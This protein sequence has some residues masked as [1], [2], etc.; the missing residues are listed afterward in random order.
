V[1]NLTKLKKIFCTNQ[2]S[3]IFVTIIKTLFMKLASFLTFAVLFIG[4]VTGQSENFRFQNLMETAPHETIATAVTNEGSKTFEFLADQKIT[5]KYATKEWVYV[6]MTPSQLH[7]AQKSGNIKEFHFEFSVPMTLGDTTLKTHRINQVHAGTNGLPAAYTGANV[8]VGVVD[9][10]LDY[11]HPD[12]KNPDGTTR[13]LRY[14]DHTLPL[15]ANRTP[16]PYNYGQV[17]T[18]TD[19]NAGTCGSNEE[20]TGHGTTVTGA[21]AGNGLANGR[22]KGVAPGCNIIF[23]E[24]NFN[25]QNW[26]LTIAD[27]CDYIFK[28][29]DSLNMPAVVNLSLGTYLGSHDGND[30]A[31]VRIENLVDE[32]LGRIVVCAAGNSGAQAPYHVRGL[33]Q[34]DTTFVWMRNNPSGALGANT[35]YFDLWAQPSDVANLSFSFGA[36]RPTDFSNAGSLTYRP[37]TG[38]IG[39]PIF[40]TL[41]NENGQ[42]LGTIQIYTSFSLGAYRME[43]YFSKVDSTSYLYRFSTAG[44]GKYDLWSGTFL[45][46]NQ[47]VTNVPSEAQFPAIANY[48]MPDSLQSIVS[49]WNCSEKVI[50]VGNMRNRLTF[51]DQNGN[52]YSDPSYPMAVGELSMNSSKGPSRLD[53]VKPDITANGDLSLASAPLWIVNS[54]GYNGA[55]DELGMHVLNG[56]T[57]MA[58]PVVAGIAALYLE[59]CKTSSYTNFKNDLT[60]NAMQDNFTGTTP[61]FAY[62]YGKADALNTLLFNATIEGGPVYC[63]QPTDLTV[64]AGSQ[65]NTVT[66]N[67]GTVSN[68][69]TVNA[70][71]TYSAN[72]TYNGTCL[73]TVEITLGLGTIPTTPEITSNGFTLTSTLADNYQWFLNG[74]PISGATNQTL[75]ITEGG[76]YTVSTTSIDGCVATSTPLNNLSVNE[77]GL[78]GISVYPNPSSGTIHLL[79]L[80]GTENL[81]LIDA[82]GKVLDS[83]LSGTVLSGMENASKGVYF[84]HITKSS[85]NFVIKIVRN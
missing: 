38:S 24:S 2:I 33:A 85:G 62:G 5:M 37:A 81:K 83:K 43:A 39:A 6:N 73:T 59:K 14:W 80:D 9:Q 23:V 19:I 67:T 30:P 35:I 63:G 28:V 84:L 31:A 56:G 70:T 13:V 45:G 36:N 48:N 44:T 68:P 72:V 34:N 53:V 41:R 79:G 21:A 42:Q 15:D 3:G 25:A 4:N 7:A 69:L 10:G 50:S 57:S 58:S 18:S 55:K 8:I 51:L 17:W 46:L 27:A 61:N 75:N 49:S 40:D 64:V 82:H 52:F 77:Q 20:T 47:L 71:G 78:H 26:T 11:N 16:Q 22:N 76:S 65:V 60:R 1:V 12:F 74:N 32:K 66:W 29:A 54:S